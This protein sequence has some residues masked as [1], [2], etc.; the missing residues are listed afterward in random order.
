[1]KLKVGDKLKV[2]EVNDNSQIDNNSEIGDNKFSPDDA[3]EINEENPHAPQNKISH[4]VKDEK[5]PP[6]ALTLIENKL[7]KQLASMPKQKRYNMK[8][9]HGDNVLLLVAAAD[10]HST[11]ARY[12]RHLTNSGRIKSIPIE[13]PE[14]VTIT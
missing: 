1:M 13:N 2:D 9:T 8:Q 6:D 7:Q 3:Y 10:S 4:E 11:F 12:V 14:N 5:N